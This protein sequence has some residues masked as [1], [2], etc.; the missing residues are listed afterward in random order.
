MHVYS[1]ILPYLR[2]C[3]MLWY[4]YVNIWLFNFCFL[5]GLCRKCQWKWL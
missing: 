2:N 1:F 3:D 4:I 5:F